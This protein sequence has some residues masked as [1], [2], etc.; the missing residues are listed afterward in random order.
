MPRRAADLLARIGVCVAD[1]F[2]A[3]WATKVQYDLLRPITY[4]KRVIDPKWEPLLNTP[5]FPEYPSG[6]STQ[7]G[8]AAVVLTA[9][10][11]DNYKFLDTT[12]TDE[13]MKG[14]EY[15]VLHGRGRGGRDFPPLRWHPL[16][17]RH[18]RR[19]APGP[20]HGCLY[21]RVEDI[22]M[23]AA[24]ILTLLASPATAQTIPQFRG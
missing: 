16:P 1:A 2:I 12:H 23:R 17:R 13:G 15:P 18:R 6:H 5:P 24:L 21:R 22:V 20:L 4:I 8:A 9:F 19:V 10:F 14:R 3:C 11:G 7:S